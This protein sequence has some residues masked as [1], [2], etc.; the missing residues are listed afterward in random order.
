MSKYYY[1]NS[2]GERIDLCSSPL[3][4][5]SFNSL[6]SYAYEPIERNGTVFGHQRRKN[7]EKAM[8]LQ[9]YSS[10]PEKFA[11]FADEMY[12]VTNYDIQAGV[13]GTLYIGDFFAR[14][15]FPTKAVAEFNPYKRMVIVDVPFF[16]PEEVWRRELPAIILNGDQSDP[17]SVP[18]IPLANYP[19]NYPHGYTSGNLSNDFINDSVFPS[20]FRLAI[21]GSC[22]NPSVTIGGHVYNVNVSVPAGSLLIIDS[23]EKTIVLYDS[24]NVG[25]N[26]FAYQNHDAD[27]YIFEPIPVGEVSIRYQNIPSITLTLYEE[28]SAP[29][30]I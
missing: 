20:P 25:Q 7:V 13:Y 5:E 4:A 2:R 29:K 21:F 8:R 12:R 1:V 9:Y 28:R 10:D 30:W 15:N 17:S 23:S 3:W 22:T 24:N 27:K 18:A 14:G 19:S 16:M 26:V 11:A 6:R